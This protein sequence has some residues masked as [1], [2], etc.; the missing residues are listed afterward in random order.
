MKISVCWYIP[1]MRIRYLR[2]HVGSI[3]NAFATPLTNAHEGVHRSSGEGAS[4][5][6]VSCSRFPSVFPSAALACFT[7][8]NPDDLPAA[9]ELFYLNHVRSQAASD[10]GSQGRCS[11]PSAASIIKSMAQAY[12]SGGRLGRARWAG[13]ETRKGDVWRLGGREWVD[14]WTVGDKRGVVGGLMGRR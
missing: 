11:G 1:M 12:G 4:E 14:G 10:L 8:G 3:S 6:M 5:H 7:W 9:A 2:H 13:R